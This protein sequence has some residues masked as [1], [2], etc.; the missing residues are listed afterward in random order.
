[1]QGVKPLKKTESVNEDPIGNE[2]VTSD[3]L[4]NAMPG[5]IFLRTTQMYI[6]LQILFQAMTCLSLQDIKRCFEF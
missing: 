2:S 6:V 5:H 4:V 3:Q 1:V